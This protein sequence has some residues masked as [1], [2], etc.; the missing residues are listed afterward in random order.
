MKTF[1]VER[2]GHG[3]FQGRREFLFLSRYDL[4]HARER[5][6]FSIRSKTRAGRRRGGGRRRMRKRGREWRASRETEKKHATLYKYERVIDSV[7]TNSTEPTRGVLSRA[8]LTLF[9]LRFLV[10]WLGPFSRLLPPFLLL[11]LLSPFHLHQRS[12]VFHA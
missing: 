7:I 4:R 9:H 6:F 10:C 1:I 3:S 11:L 5:R 8:F 12:C 2:H